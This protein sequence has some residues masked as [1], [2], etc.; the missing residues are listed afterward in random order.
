MPMIDFSYYHKIQNVYGTQN[1]REKELAK[2]NRQAYKQYEDTVDTVNVLKN[3]E[4]SKLM[5]VKGAGPE[6]YRKDVK[7]RRGERLKLGDMITW[8]H[9]H[10]M[11]TA[12]DPDDKTWNTGS[13]QLCTLLLSWQN[14]RG[15]IVRRWCCIE[16]MARPSC[17]IREN[18]LLTVG[19]S[20]LNI[21]LALDEETKCLRRDKRFVI[22]AAGTEVPDAY[23]L[24]DRDVVTSNWDYFE[25]GGILKLTLSSDL[26]NREKDQLVTL[27]TGETVWIADCI[28]SPTPPP[29]DP[30]KELIL[31]HI[32][33]AGNP[34]IVIGSSYKTFTARF[35]DSRGNPLSGIT[36]KWTVTTADRN[37]KDCVH[38]MINND[39]TIQ[40]K[41]DYSDSLAGKYVKLDLSDGSGTSSSSVLIELG[42]G[43]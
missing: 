22:D 6:A 34:R 10:W 11:V 40:I 37:T 27:H 16:H 13:M 43:I 17:G 2:I 26:F 4:P 32:E 42:G 1:R 9:M 12:M 15:A 29:P 41:A 14:S 23:K 38:Y 3:G 21:Q 28:R 8:N 18:E 5:I 25:R 19:D 31:S 24:T 30:V 39:N 7:S 35:T 36:A 20:Q 33:F